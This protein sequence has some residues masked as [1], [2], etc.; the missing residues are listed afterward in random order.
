MSQAIV[1]DIGS[2]TMKGGFAGSFKPD[3]IVPSLTATKQVDPTHTQM[4]A[5][6]DVETQI[7]KFR[8]FNENFDQETSQDL[9]IHQPLKDHRNIDWEGFEK[10]WEHLAYEHL[11]VAAVGKSSSSTNPA[12]STYDDTNLLLS[13]HPTDSLKYK[14]KLLEMGYEIFNADGIYMSPTTTLGLY[15]VGKL[16]GTVVDS[17]YNNTFVASIYEGYMLENNVQL[18]KYGGQTI[19]KF[20]KTLIEQNTKHKSTNNENINIL[21]NDCEKIKKQYC[22]FANDFFEEEAMY[23]S[24]HNSEFNSNNYVLPDGKQITISNEKYQACNAY[25]N[26]IIYF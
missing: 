20:L 13:H 2:H 23:N 1:I 8:T 11:K 25:F 22:Y 10:L 26:Q 15:S 3:C 7:S 5:G 24:N 6:T 12:T 14:C 19:D 4:Y 16:T 21:L 9:K 17:G 18:S